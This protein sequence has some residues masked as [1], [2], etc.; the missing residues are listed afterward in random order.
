M[1]EGGGGLGEREIV[2]AE[3]GGEEGG[4]VLYGG[5]FACVN[6]KKG[7]SDFFFFFVFVFSNFIYV[8]HT[9]HNR[10]PRR[11]N[12]IDSYAD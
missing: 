1:G 7:M 12:R 3:G 10:I 6:R 11:S 2:R 5:D 4:A 8:L 9:M